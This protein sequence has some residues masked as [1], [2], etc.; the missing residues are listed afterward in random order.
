MYTIDC[1]F[2]FFVFFGNDNFFQAIFVGNDNFRYQKYR[3]PMI[4]QIRKNPILSM[5]YLKKGP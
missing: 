5:Y 2:F 3:A 4:V 1:P